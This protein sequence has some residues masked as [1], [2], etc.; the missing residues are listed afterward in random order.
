MW[1][2]LFLLDRNIFLLINHLPHNALLNDIALAISGIGSYGFI[3]FCLGLWLFFRE[4]KNDHQFWFK[5]IPAFLIADFLVEA[6]FKPIM[7]RVRPT[8]DIGAVIIG[9]NINDSY[10]FPSGHA[11]IAF[12]LATVLA[13]KEP[14]YKYWFYLLAILIA[15]SR[16]YLGKHY[17]FD[18]IVGAILGYLLG[19]LWVYIA[20]MIINKYFPKSVRQINTKRKR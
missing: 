15:L 20:N 14:K 13:Y 4:E 7:G 2:N 3:W 16:I 12:T 18:V 11:T 5:L 10:S 9:S 17:P 1:E 19:H 6:I 8:I